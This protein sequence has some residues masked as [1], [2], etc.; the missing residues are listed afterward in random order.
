MYLAHK[1][2]KVANVPLVPEV[3][4]PDELFKIPRKNC[5]GL[6]ISPD[7]LNEIRLERLKALGLGSKASYASFERI[8]DELDYAE[9]IMKRVGCPIINVSNKAIEETAGLILEVLKKENFVMMQKFV[10]L[11]HEGNGN[12]KETLGGK[13][14][15]LAEMTRIGLP[16]PFGFTISTQACNAYYDAGKM[17]PTIVES[18]VLG[19]LTNLEEKM[20]KKLGDA[21]NPLLVSVRSGS[22]FSMPG[23]MDTVLNLGM[24]DKTVVGMGNL[25]N[26]PRFAYDSYRRFIQ[27]FSNVV[28]DINTFHFEQLLEETREQ[29]VIMPTRK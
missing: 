25:T 22:V 24:N 29:R 15:N 17:I 28:L 13:G 8:L 18:Q 7:K 10:Y 2:F 1:R 11:F 6:I 4:A 26:N 23:M 21:E 19:A 12:M 9:K 14:A 3:P 27:M 16:V 5:I 20:G